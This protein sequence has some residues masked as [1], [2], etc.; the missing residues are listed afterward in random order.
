MKRFILDLLKKDKEYIFDKLLTESRKRKLNEF[1]HYLFSMLYAD[2]VKA[3]GL[4]I[5]NNE[6]ISEN[7]NIS[8][9]QP[10]LIDSL[11]QNFRRNE[12]ERSD[13]DK[14]NKLF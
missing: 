5:L 8:V 3:T 10:F 11:K 14:K 12:F 6:L 2:K 7:K 4:V 1:E 9:N 13:L